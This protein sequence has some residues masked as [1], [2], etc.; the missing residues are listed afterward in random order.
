MDITEV[1]RQFVAYASGDLSEA[2]LRN[3]I[4][5]ALVND[6][7]LST[8]Y[9]ALTEAYRRADVIDAEL[10]SS[11]VAD[12]AEFSASAQRQPAVR[13]VHEPSGPSDATLVVAPP[14]GADWD[15]ADWL[16]QSTAAVS[17]GT[18]LNDHYEL[19]EELGRGGMGVVYKALDRRAAELHD[20]HCYVAVK[21]LSEDF[22]RHPLA[23][24]SLQRETRKAQRLAHPN[25]L[26]VFCFDRD[27]GTA[28]MVMEL[29]LGHSLDQLIRKDGKQGL[30]LQRVSQIVKSLGSALSH[31]H[32]QGIIHS[33]FK[34]SNAFLTDEGVV[35]VL[36]FGI[37]RAAPSAGWGDYTLFDAGQLGAVCPAYATLEMLNG[38]QPDVR[39]DVFALAAVTYELLTGRHPFNRIDAQ[40]AREAG[41]EPLPVRGISRTQWQALKRGLAFERKARTPSIDEFV[42]PFIARRARGASGWVAAATM[43]GLAIGLSLFAWSRWAGDG[44]LRARIDQLEGSLQTWL[45]AEVH[46]VVTAGRVEH[47]ERRLAKLDP[48]APAYLDEALASRDDLRVLGTLAPASPTFVRA[49]SALADAVS[50]RVADDLADDDIAGAE[51]LLRDVSGVLSEQDLVAARASLAAAEKAVGKRGA[52]ALEAEAARAAVREELSTLISKP[53][54]SERWATSVHELMRK[55]APLVPAD[56]PAFSTARQIAVSTFVIAAV[57]AHEAKQYTSAANLLDTARSFDPQSS[58]IAQE[59]AAIARDR[60]ASGSGTAD[61]P[62]RATEAID[63][64]ALLARKQLAGG[65]VDAA[66][67]TLANA[68]RKF[69][70]DE[71]LK[72]LEVRY[73]TIAEVYDVLSTAVSL[74][75]SEQRTA[76]EQLRITEGDDYAA[77]E[78]ML[79]RALGNR[80]ADERAAGRPLVAAS[81][82]RSGREIFPDEAV[83][84]EPAAPDQPVV[85][86]PSKG[87]QAQSSATAENVTP[88]QSA[89]EPDDS[90]SH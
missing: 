50:R 39:D 63:G 22:K 27:G 76:L 70:R 64:Y 1:R 7:V 86:E 73:V 62:Q 80:I 9:I 34:P 3:G 56:D 30:P 29:L 40:K 38:E 11:I 68:R 25:I 66:L 90:S 48:A 65:E 17:R 60:S 79:A 52:A 45:A 57:A 12:I 20:K 47:A 32:A 49:R 71:Q 81:L 5:T 83:L 4:R 14:A 24:R 51:T 61:I 44:P 54:V 28:F 37:A 88:A 43:F 85:Q 2:E 8:A 41:L 87:A 53:D 18:V 46:E 82:L 69:G 72:Q 6:P 13:R 19:I 21:V 15:S 31:A 36:D 33:D 23:V 26:T 89:T 42:A 59:A 74:N 84:F 58:Q 16:T 78:R 77:T 10:Q 35:K 67:Q 75:T 55:L